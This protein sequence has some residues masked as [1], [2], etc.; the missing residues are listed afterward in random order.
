MWMPRISPAESGCSTSILS[1]MGWGIS[2]WMNWK[3]KK[4]RDRSHAKSSPF[5]EL[6][7]ILFYGNSASGNFLFFVVCMMSLFRLPRGKL[8]L[9]FLAVPAGKD[10][11]VECPCQTVDDFIGI[12]GS[13]CGLFLFVQT[14]A[15][16]IVPPWQSRARKSKFQFLSGARARMLSAL[17]LRL[18]AR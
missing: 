16:L 3:Q 14:H 13:I 4:S 15:P 12:R 10:G 1:M 7:Q 11:W 18:V 2:L 17:Y 6:L 5:R 8:P 9:P